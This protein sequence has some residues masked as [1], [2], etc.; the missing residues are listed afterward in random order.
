MTYFEFENM[1]KGRFKEVC[2][3][4]AGRIGKTWGYDLV[5]GSGIKVDFYCDNIVPSGTIVRDGIEVRDIQYLYEN[6]ERVQVF[7]TVGQQNQKRILDQLQS[8]DIADVFIVDHKRLFEI[9]DS[10]DNSGEESVKQQYHAIYNDIEYLE[11]IFAYKTGYQL[12]IRNPQTFNEKLQWLK[13]YNRKP[14]YT[15]LVD[16]YEVKKYVGKKIGENYVIPTL[17]LWKDFDEIEFDKLPERFVLKCTHDSGSVVIVDKKGEM[18]LQQMR[19]KLSTALG[20]NYFWSQREWPYKNVP[21]RIMAEVYMSDSVQGGIN[22]YKFLCFDG[23]VRMIFT[24]TERYSKEGLKVTFFDTDWNQMSFE[25]HYPSSKKIIEKPKSLACMI[26]LAEQMSRGIPFV[27]IDFYEIESKV[28]FGEITFFPGGGMEA[29]KP[30]EWDSILGGWI[31]LPK[32]TKCSD[33]KS[34]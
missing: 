25:R 21:R 14:K 3:F 22:D 11:K 20:T 10:I 17:G 9:L 8:H 34:K 23:V 5:S 28:Y 6:K 13:I 7:L 2:L 1:Y 30:R 15:Q 33:W 4:G 24:C 19:K 18:D 31:S 26:E 16:K 12:N 27:R 29:F 32:E